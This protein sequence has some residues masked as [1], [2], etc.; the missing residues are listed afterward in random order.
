MTKPIAPSMNDSKEKVEAQVEKSAST[1][2]KH[3]GAASIAAVPS[4]LMTFFESL[5]RVGVS[6]DVKS[7]RLPTFS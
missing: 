6:V 1:P 5:T 4:K 7:G 2:V 3:D